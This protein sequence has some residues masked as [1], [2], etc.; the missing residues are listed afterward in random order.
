LFCPSS[1]ISITN[2][3]TTPTLHVRMLKY[4]IKHAICLE[5][6]PFEY[7]ENRKFG[8]DGAVRDNKVT[9]KMKS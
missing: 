3:L 8:R 4:E 2:S 7:P 6:Y 9:F 5:I 1:C